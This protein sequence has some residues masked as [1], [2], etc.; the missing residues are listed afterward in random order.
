VSSAGTGTACTQAAPCP[1]LTD[2]IGKNLPYVKVA[3]AGAAHGTSTV[4]IDG[5][6]ITILAEPGAVI[7]RDGDGPILEVRSAN[8]DVRIFDATVSGATS[9]SGAGIL[10]T[11]N[12]GQPKL[13]L[14]RVTVSNNQ[15]DGIAA[16]G[17]ALTVTQST[18]ASNQG[19]GIAVSS[20]ATFVITNNFIY[21]NGDQDTGTYGGVN[22]AV[23]TAGSNV[24]EFNTVVDNRA[25][26]GATR[27]GGVICD[28]AGFAAPN[29]VIA[30]NAVGANTTVSNAQTL[31]VC[32]YPTSKVQNDHTGLA[33]VSAEAAP[34]DYR[35]L[36][37]SVAIDQA[38][39]TSSIVVDHDGD[40][41]PQGAQKDCGADE[42]K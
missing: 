15:G 29:N 38:T 11:A 33:F 27:G 35:L 3:A 37:G 2:A 7:D 14:T 13:A 34:F 42:Y 1:L 30:R 5:K 10:V 17:G 9:A 32:T 18:I 41:R 21:R 24:F 25:S 4:V 40:L 8:A 19:G 31:G 12:G 23:A 22:L 6:A 16:S 36:V 28:I 39:T 20:G 26:T